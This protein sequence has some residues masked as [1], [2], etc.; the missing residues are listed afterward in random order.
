MS[1]P[2]VPHLFEPLEIGGLRLKNRIIMAPLTRSRDI[3][4]RE[5]LHVPYYAERAGVGLI[6]RIENAEP[7]TGP[8][9]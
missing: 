5:N 2:K 1:S 6:V 9:Y 3:I 7:I 4:P 8:R